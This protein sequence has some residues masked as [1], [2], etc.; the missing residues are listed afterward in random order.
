MIELRFIFIFVIKLLK[1][2]IN[3]GSLKARSRNV[4]QGSLVLTKSHILNCLEYIG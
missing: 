4:L 3:L 2:H 1:F